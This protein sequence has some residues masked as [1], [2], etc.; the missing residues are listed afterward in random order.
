[1]L[2]CYS[3]NKTLGTLLLVVILTAVV[4]LFFQNTRISPSSPSKPVGGLFSP[5]DEK[6]VKNIETKTYTIDVDMDLTG[7]PIIDTL[8]TGKV[9]E[10]VASFEDQYDV[11][12]FTDEEFTELGFAD[13]RK[14]SFTVRGGFAHDAQLYSYRTDMSEYT[15]GAHGN[16]SVNCLVFTVD[17]GVQELKSF[18]VSGSAYLSVLAS[19]VPARVQQEL[20]K[21]V[22]EYSSED[23]KTAD[24]CTREVTGMV[25][26]GTSA[27]AENYSTFQITD[28]GI[29]FI[30][31]AYQVAPYVFGQPQVEVSW[32]ELGNIVAR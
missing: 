15:G 23:A 30:F 27:T 21:T 7:V 2:Y 6:Y 20:C 13:G 28:T 31:Q 14:Y 18:F 1:M 11:S 9:D 12:K 26:D 22:T 3:M 17:G 25:A 10:L 5:R 16:P 4:A 24:E 32:A 8:V 29:L 19:I